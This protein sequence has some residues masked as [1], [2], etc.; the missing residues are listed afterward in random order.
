LNI[1]IKS[2]LNIG[3]L[4]L[5]LY[6]SL[7][8]DIPGTATRRDPPIKGLFAATVDPP[9]TEDPLFAENLNPTEDLRITLPLPPL[10]R[11]YNTLEEAIEAINKLSLEYGYAVVKQRSKKTKR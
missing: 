1:I 11:R 5:E 10:D 8:K 4:G 3:G 7:D 9:A 2:P 6:Y